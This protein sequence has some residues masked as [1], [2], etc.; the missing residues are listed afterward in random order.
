MAYVARTRQRTNQCLAAAP[1]HILLFR[2][3]LHRKIAAEIP[4]AHERDTVVIRA[5]FL[6]RPPPATTHC[7]KQPIEHVWEK[8]SLARGTPPLTWATQRLGDHRGQKLCPNVIAFVAMKTESR[9]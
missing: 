1:V 9:K 6:G 5:A 7:V 3:T 4:T 2:S 8:T